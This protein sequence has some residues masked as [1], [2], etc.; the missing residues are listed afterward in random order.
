MVPRVLALLALSALCVGTAHALPL[1]ISEISDFADSGFANVGTL[2]VGVNTVS[3]N[4]KG[5]LGSILEDFQDTFSVTLP[6]G[7]RI[8]AGQVVITDFRYCAA[9]PVICGVFEEFSELVDGEITEPLNGSTTIDANGT[10][11]LS[12]NVPFSTPGSLEVDVTSAF[13]AFTI[14]I[15]GQLS[16]LLQ[17]TVETLLPGPG[18]PGV[19]EPAL[20]LLLGAGAVALAGRAAR[21][22]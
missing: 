10:H 4:V 17:Y 2:E 15:E 18:V 8:S 16:Y 9:E 21:R 22:H 12:L 6:P 13:L 20:W 7:L 14:P 11:P 19:P 5:F 1:A 3:G